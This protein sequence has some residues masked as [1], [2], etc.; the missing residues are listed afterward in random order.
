MRIG[1]LGGTFDP[2]HVAHVELARTAIEALGLD[3][4]KVLPAG[5]PWHRS[6]QPS[7]AADRLAM[8]RLAFGDMPHVEVDDRETLRAGATYTIDTVRELTREQPQAQWFLIVGAD[9]ARRFQTWH[10][11]EELLCLVHLVVAE[12]DAEAGQWQN[13]AMSKARSLPFDPIDISATAIR[14]CVAQ[15]LQVSGLDPKVLDYIR[16]HQ[17]YI[18]KST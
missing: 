16:Q 13:D 4:L 6:F 11:W 2:P 10:E 5:Q 7:P 3:R 1:L 12:R 15:G 9:Q 8:C 14:S 18:F 17:L